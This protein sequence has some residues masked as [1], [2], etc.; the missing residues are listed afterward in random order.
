MKISDGEILVGFGRELKMPDRS[1]VV[2]GSGVDETHVGED[3]GG[4]ADFL[5]F[6]SAASRVSIMLEAEGVGGGHSRKTIEE[7]RQTF[8]RHTRPTRKPKFLARL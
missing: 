5:R 4:I 8:R 7:R 6:Q 2:T 3:L 1:F